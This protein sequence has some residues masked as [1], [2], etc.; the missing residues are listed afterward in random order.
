MAL[1]NVSQL[2]TLDSKSEAA[3]GRPERVEVLTRVCVDELLEA[4]GLGGVGRGRRPLELLSRV[5]AKR[6]ARQVATYDEIVGESGLAAGGT[7]A[8]GRMARRVEVEGRENVPADGPLLL[9]ANHPGLADALALFATV[10]REDLRVVAAERPFLAALPNT[11]RYLIP[12]SEASHPKRF[13]AVR[14]ATRHLKGGGAILTFPGGKIEPDPAVLPG[15]IQA[16]ERWSESLDLFAR[17]VPDLTV[18]PAVVSGVLSPT[19]LRNPLIFVRR[20]P[21]DREWLAASI[22]MMTPALRNVTTQI[23]FGRP[24][25][26]GNVPERT[27]RDAVLEEARRLIERYEAR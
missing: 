25:H 17:L 27:V 1:D 16:L 10:P 5:P 23:A 14:I 8:L 18:V 9:V 13:G 2:P 6:L 26:N 19:A 12:V 3:P 20:R 4:F 24:V 7:W 15:A 11:S 22:Q 21:R